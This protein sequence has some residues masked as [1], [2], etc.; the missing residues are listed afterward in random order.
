MTS[1]HL[2]LCI[3]CAWFLDHKINLFIISVSTLDI[4]RLFAITFVHRYTT[5]TRD[6]KR[7]IRNKYPCF[8]F[9]NVS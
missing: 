2:Y 6:W 7:V 1:I 4:C 5:L 8:E 9:V 3:K